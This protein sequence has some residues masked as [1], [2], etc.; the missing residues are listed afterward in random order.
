MYLW[1]PCQRSDCQSAKVSLSARSLTWAY[2]VSFLWG[3]KRE[4]KYNLYVFIF[5]EKV[6]L[7]SYEK[8]HD[9]TV[10]VTANVHRELRLDLFAS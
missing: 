3:I 9:T 5:V 10:H 1:H 7:L 2:S 4:V 8:K 6:I